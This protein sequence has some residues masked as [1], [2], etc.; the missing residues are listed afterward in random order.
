MFAIQVM[1]E[2]DLGTKLCTHQDKIIISPK[3]PK[4]NWMDCVD[5]ILTW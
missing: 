5:T 4:T 2:T 1:I 3:S